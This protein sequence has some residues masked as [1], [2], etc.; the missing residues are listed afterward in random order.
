MVGVAYC[1]SDSLEVVVVI[2]ASGNAGFKSKD[3]G[4]SRNA[5]FK[6]K[7]A[8]DSRNAGFKSKD[9]GDSRNAG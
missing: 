2:L 7:D 6:S 3:A 1:S 4:D 9:A 8:G 5:G